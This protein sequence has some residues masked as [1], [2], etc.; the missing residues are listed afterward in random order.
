MGTIPGDLLD[1]F[2]RPDEDG[3]RDRQVQGLRR[4]QVDHQL[5]LGRLLDGQVGG[6]GALGQTPYLAES[7]SAT[8]PEWP[9]AVPSGRS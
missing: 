6:F 3:R 5:E 2:I 8:A 9:A 7:A 4:L 1:H